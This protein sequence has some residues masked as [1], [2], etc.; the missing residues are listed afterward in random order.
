MDEKITPLLFEHYF[1]KS[2][3]ITQKK[4][5]KL[6]GSIIAQANFITLSYRSRGQEPRITINKPINKTLVITP[7]R[8]F[9]LNPNKQ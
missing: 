3:T 1:N 5:T 6:R 4:Y 8:E 9:T 2:N 7:K